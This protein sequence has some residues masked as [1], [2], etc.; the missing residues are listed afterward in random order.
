[1]KRLFLTLSVF[2]AVSA[3][4][5]AAT[6]YQGIIDL[7]KASNGARIPTTI[8]AGVYSVEV[9]VNDHSAETSGDIILSKSH[10]RDDNEMICEVL[11]NFKVAEMNLKIKSLTGNWEKQTKNNI[12]VNFGSR[13]DTTHCLIAAYEFEGQREYRIDVPSTT[14]ELPVNDARFTSV[15][16]RIR[17]FIDGVKA[18]YNLTAGLA[19]NTLS[20]S[21]PGAPFKSVLENSGD[22]RMGHELSLTAGGYFHFDTVLTTLKRV[23]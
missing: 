1:M 9:S 7:S 20:V 3:N 5:N 4:A 2:I 17:P 11:G 19:S 22:N 12:Y 18:A 14:V 10:Y 8:N 15:K 6:S 16:L 13:V 21:Y 23:K